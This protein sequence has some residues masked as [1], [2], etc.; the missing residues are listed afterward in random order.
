MYNYHNNAFSN[1]NAFRDSHVQ[2]ECGSHITS[3]VRNSSNEKKP[4]CDMLIEQ[5]ITYPMVYFVLLCMYLICRG[6]HMANAMINVSTLHKLGHRV[7]IILLNA[8]F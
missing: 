3:A 5:K 2:V 1:N 8:F 6:S 4:K 7:I